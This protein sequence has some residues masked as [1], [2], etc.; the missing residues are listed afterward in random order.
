MSWFLEGGFPLLKLTIIPRSKGSLGFAQYLPNESQL[1]TKR[2]IVDQICCALGGR[3][4][5]EVFFGR[6]T[7]GASDDL[8][9]VHSLAHAL[10]T[11]FG[12]SDTLGLINYEEGKYRKEYSDETSKVRE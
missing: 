12:M 2:E 1:L 10:V 3:V 5:E 7:T 4:C 9:K 11:K 8:K 6:I